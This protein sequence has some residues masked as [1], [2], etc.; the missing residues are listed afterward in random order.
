MERIEL[1]ET[2]DPTIS[3]EDI[4]IAAHKIAVDTAPGPDHVLVRVIRNEIVYEIL[5]IIATRM[6]SSGIVPRCFKTARTVLIHKAADVNILSNWRPITICSVLRRVIERV[7]DKHLRTFVSFN[8]H[9]RG[10]TNNSG[11][12]INTSILRKVLKTTK[13]NKEDVTVVFLDISKAFDNIGHKH[14]DLTLSAEPIPAKLKDLIINLQINNT[15]NTQTSLGQTKAINLR[16]GVMQGSPLSPTLYNLATD[17]I[18]D[19]LTELSLLQQYGKS[20]SPQLSSLSIM[21]F[22]DDTLLMGKNSETTLELLHIALQRFQEIGLQVNPQKCT[23][24][25]IKRGKLVEEVLHIN[26]KFTIKTINNQEEVRYLGVPFQDNALFDKDSTIKQLHKKLELLASSPLLKSDQK[27]LVLNT[28]I[29]PTLIYRFQTTDLQTIPLQFLHTADKL[30]RSTLKDILQLP[31]DIPDS[32]LYSSCQNKGLGLFKAAW[33][34]YLQHINACNTLL[35]SQNSHVLHL[36]TLQ[37]DIS[38]CLQ[39][40]NITNT[41]LH[42]NNHT[43]LID[44]RK[45]RNELRLRE[46]ENW[47]HL[48]HKGV[49]IDLYKE[50]TPANSWIRHHRGLSCSEWREAIKMQ[51]NVSAVR[52]VPGR[53]L[54]GNLCRRCNREKETLG[55][56]LGSCP[57]GEILRNARHHKLRSFIAEQLRRKGYTV[58]EEI[59]GI[60]TQ[61]STRRIDILAFQPNSTKGYIIDPTI[62]FEHHTNQP[63][64]V[65]AEKQN[66]YN[67]TIP[68]YKS[69]YHLQDIT[70]IGLMV[71]ARGTI[72]SLFAKF[73]SEFHL[74]KKKI[75]D[76]V[77]TTLRGSVQILRCHLFGP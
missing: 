18:F 49:G 52:T 71:G 5:A 1:D 65:N 70:V 29:C 36:C 19:E 33:E 31:T 64:E 72:P 48:P 44:T 58:Y 17:F 55:H 30:V 47:S 12:L 63:A 37:A 16:R 60:A 76:V 39:L 34:I 22:A 67:P 32:T 13:D 9:Q 51:A 14:L 43:G 11:T 77:T 26:E 54:D 62:R 50:Y 10:F 3:K 61:G 41:D 24:I 69:Q 57:Y 66:I 59:H 73:W 35:K 15:T 27:F 75:Y 42:I 28:A 74:P 45:I 2:Y 23:G 46:T 56:V 20:I 25:S 53:S 40:L 6:L 21:G 8:E 68:Y 4:A 38:T 7:L